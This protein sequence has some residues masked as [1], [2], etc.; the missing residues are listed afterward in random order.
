MEKDKSCDRKSDS[1]CALILAAGYSSR[2][3]DFKPMMPVGG[4]PAIVRLARTFKKAGIKRIVAV[5]G[6]KRELLEHVL[7]E[8]HIEEAFNED[9][10]EG[11][12]SSVKAGVLAAVK[13]DPASPS[14]IMLIPADHPLITEDVIKL[15]LDEHIKHPGN[16]IVPCYM[17]KKGHPLLVPAGFF[18]EILS[19]EG[20]G[21]LREITSRHDDKMFLI[22]TDCEAVVLNMDTPESYKEIQ[23]YCEKQKDILEGNT[24]GLKDALS[25]HRLFL[26]R[27]GE[28]RQH[29]EKIFLGQYDVPLSDKGREQAEKAGTELAEY[30]ISADLFFSSDLCRAEETAMII[31]E[32][33]YSRKEIKTGEDRGPAKVKGIPE[34]REMSLGEWDGKFISEMKTRYPEEYKK[35]G[36]NLLGFKFDNDSENYYDLRYRVIKGLEKILGSYK[37][38]DIIIVTHSGVIKVLSSCL[39]GTPLMQEVKN[40]VKHGEI[41]TFIIDEGNSPTYTS[42]CMV[43]GE[44]LFSTPDKPLLAKCHYCGKEEVTHTFCMNGHYVCDECH[45]GSILKLVEEVCINSDLADPVPLALKVF[46]LPQLNMH[47]PEYHSIVPGVLIAAYYNAQNRKNNVAV[48]EAISRGK[49]IAGRMCGTHGTCG[50]CIGVGIAYSIIHKVTPFSKEERGE[51]NRMTA[52]ALEAISRFGGPRCCKR[53]SMASIE[54][55]KRNFGCFSD[56]GERYICSQYYDND[57]CIGN[58]CTYYPG[59][60]DE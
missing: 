41:R 15:L 20:E 32:V 24:A 57:S 35:R 44:E 47:G 23:R 43:C 9:F 46:S 27:H 17:G 45:R 13:G 48:K 40:H 39:N 34:L 1:V 3:G 59:G 6:H 26:I 52:L 7:A 16:L 21:G 18:N 51:A 19:Y 30:G 11:M 53:D 2:M 58:E 49:T 42:G 14:G 55:A 28:T 4:V 5:T 22:E 12:Y 31:S 25:G 54:V 37:G 56:S 29:A 38:R 50:A 60:N 33:L 10:N 8:N 36:E